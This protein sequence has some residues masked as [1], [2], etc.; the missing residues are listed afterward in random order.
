MPGEVSAADF[1]S[2]SEAWEDLEFVVKAYFIFHDLLEARKT[3]KKAL[4]TNAAVFAAREADVNVDVTAA[5]AALVV[6]RRLHLLLVVV[7]RRL[8]HELV[9]RRRRLQRLEALLLRLVVGEAGAVAK[10]GGSAWPGLA[11]RGS[12]TRDRRHER[13][14]RESARE[15]REWRGQT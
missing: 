3:R 9:P 1:T 14:T 6:L 10:G 4:K 8:R 13:D 11:A 12:A 5:G 15:G 7:L 2:L